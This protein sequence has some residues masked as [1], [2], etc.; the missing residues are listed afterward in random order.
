MYI[1][2][3]RG[4]ISKYFIAHRLYCAIIVPHSHV[5][6]SAQSF[7]ASGIANKQKR[8]MKLLKKIFFP[9]AYGCSG[10]T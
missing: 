5:I 9:Y 1:L 10:T 7:K 3:L 6:S 4:L 8:G 2:W